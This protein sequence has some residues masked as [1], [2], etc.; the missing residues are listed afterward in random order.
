MIQYPRAL[1]LHTTVAVLGG[2]LLG[3]GGSLLAMY[4][5]FAHWARL[6]PHDGQIGLGV[7][8]VGLFSFP[9]FAVALGIVVFIIQRRWSASALPFRTRW[10]SRSTIV[11]KEGFSIWVGRDQISYRRNNRAMTMTS[12]LG[13]SEINIFASTANRWDDDV[14]V[15][16]GEDTK[17]SVLNDV[18]RALEWKGLKVNLLP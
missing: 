14:S 15:E 13:G 5:S 16:V 7:L 18:R 17:I 12:D 1:W 11:A 9:P 3:L 10:L 4:L 8:A 2:V 6:Y